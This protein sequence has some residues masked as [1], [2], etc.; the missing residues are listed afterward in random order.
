MNPNLTL[1]PATLRSNDPRVAYLRESL[2]R[3]VT[4]T[5]AFKLPGM[6]F[7]EPPDVRAASD[8]TVIRWAAQLVLLLELDPTP[9]EARGAPSPLPSIDEA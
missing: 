6:F 9:I 5:L 7:P 8:D 4:A 1:L 2:A 3:A